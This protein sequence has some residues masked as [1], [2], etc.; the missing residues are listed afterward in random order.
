[1]PRQ[2]KHGDLV[3]RMADGQAMKVGTH[4]H[5]G[6]PDELVLCYWHDSLGQYHQKHF[7]PNELTDANPDPDH[8]SSAPPR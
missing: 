8:A 3:W 1:M 7:R 6:E 4:V 2:W 5:P